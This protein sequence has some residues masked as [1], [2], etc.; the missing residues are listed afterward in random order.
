MLTSTILNSTTRIMES[1]IWFLQLLRAVAVLAVVLNHSV[2]GFCFL[3]KY[4]PNEQT[5]FSIIDFNPLL[6]LEYNLNT[7]LGVIGVAIFFLISGFVIPLS[8]KK[9]GA[10]P[11]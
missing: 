7:H 2:I 8:I 5:T 10:F 3:N 9:Y 4:L 11:F 6:A 1:R